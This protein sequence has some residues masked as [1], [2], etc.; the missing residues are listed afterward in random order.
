MKKNKT[1]IPFDKL[2]LLNYILVKRGFPPNSEMKC[3]F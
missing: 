1:I 3:N 2:N